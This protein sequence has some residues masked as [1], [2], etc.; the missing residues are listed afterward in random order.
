MF[1]AISDLSPLK[2]RAAAAGKCFAAS[3]TKSRTA[4]PEMVGGCTHTL[5]RHSDDGNS[6]WAIALI[7]LFDEI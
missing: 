1:P 4:C 6:I 7:A 2:S 3:Q 5:R